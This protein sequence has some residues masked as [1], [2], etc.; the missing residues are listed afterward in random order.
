[1]EKILVKQFTVNPA[2]FLKKVAAGQ[3]II[4]LD[5]GKIIAKLVPPGYPNI[6]ARKKLEQLQKTAIVGD[7]IS[8]TEA[9]WE[10]AE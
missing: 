10:S 9:K 8:P 6:A 5:E 3:T 1:M 7:V 2:S 4:I